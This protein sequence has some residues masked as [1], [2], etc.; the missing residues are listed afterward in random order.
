MG[1]MPGFA[2]VTG[3]S[4]GIGRSVALQLARDGYDVA[5]CYHSNTAAAE[6]VSAQIAALG[7]RVF[8]HACDVSDFQA[9]DDFIHMAREQLGQPYIL[10]NSAGIVRD[11]PLL[12][13]EPEAWHAVLDTNLTGV[14]NTCR[15]LAFYFMKQKNGIIINMSSASGVHGNAT[16]SNYA[17]AKA[18][19]IG[20]SKSLAK[21]V[22]QYNVRVNVVAPGLI[23]T[24]MTANLDSKL[25]ERYL[26]AIPLRRFGEPEEVADLVSFLVSS[27]ARY[28]TGQVIQIDGG[29]IL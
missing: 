11:N 8:A 6:D 29:I 10:V 20:F 25:Q 16:Q 9:V 15:N 2:V 22:G 5:F 13:M 24:D 21:E 1:E 23:R 14:F 12:L 7:R 17:A 3:A 27:R 26:G 19:I 4:R 18:G 28:I